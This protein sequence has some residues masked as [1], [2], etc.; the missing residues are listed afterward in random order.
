MQ[1]SQKKPDPPKKGSPAWTKKILNPVQALRRDHYLAISA[2]TPQPKYSR[3]NA[4]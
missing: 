4:A 2:N 1:S 3:V